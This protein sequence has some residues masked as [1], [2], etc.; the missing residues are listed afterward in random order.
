MDQ[1]V[2]K[3][4]SPKKHFVKEVWARSKFA[5]EEDGQTRFCTRRVLLGYFGPDL[6]ISKLVL[7]LKEKGLYFSLGS[8]EEEPR[9]VMY[10][11]YISS[12]VVFDTFEECEN[13][14]RSGISYE[15]LVETAMI[16]SPF[17]D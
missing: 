1:K 15:S 9:F 10:N 8:S 6:E 13:F 17:G 3:I 2:M 11:R 7:F 14:L 5:L 4:I 12:G 16:V